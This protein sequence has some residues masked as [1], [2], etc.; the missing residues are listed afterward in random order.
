MF[1]SGSE[2]ASRHHVVPFRPAS[3][4]GPGSFQNHLSAWQYSDKS[5]PGHYHLFCIWAVCH[6][7]AWPALPVPASTS[8]TR[9]S[10]S[11]VACSMMFC[12]SCLCSSTGSASFC[13]KNSSERSNEFLISRVRASGSI[14]LLV[15]Y[16]DSM[17]PLCP[18]KKTLKSCAI[19]PL[20]SAINN[21]VSKYARNTYGLH[22]NR[23]LN[24]FRTSLLMRGVG[25][26]IFS[27]L[28]PLLV[29]CVWSGAITAEFV[30]RGFPC[31]SLSL[32]YASRCCVAGLVVNVKY[33]IQAN[34]YQEPMQQIDKVNAV[35]VV[36]N[37]FGNIK[38]TVRATGFSDSTVRRYVSMARL[39][40]HVSQSNYKPQ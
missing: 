28:R 21:C 36:Y 24:T 18:M 38:D 22:L 11:G 32:R 34:L 13:S 17:E 8:S 16:L 39:P 3:T 35:T 33:W 6:G 26:N 40:G 20:D 19:F 7:L 12:T 25:R 30:D 37:H 27:E 14:L 9:P 4:L 10:C 1:N 2:I 31:A 5:V 23:G 15:V 29:L